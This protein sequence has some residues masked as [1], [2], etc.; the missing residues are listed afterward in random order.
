MTPRAVQFSQ[1]LNVR[2]VAGNQGAIPGTMRSRLAAAGPH[3]QGKRERGHVG[4][5]IL[6]I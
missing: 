3:S 2:I 6:L 1:S 5:E 4:T